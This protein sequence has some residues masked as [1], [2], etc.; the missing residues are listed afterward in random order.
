MLCTAPNNKHCVPMST[1]DSSRE[2]LFKPKILNYPGLYNCRQLKASNSN[3][4]LNQII[5][6]PFQW[7]LMANQRS[8]CWRVDFLLLETWGLAVTNRPLLWSW[9][10][11]KGWCQGHATIEIWHRGET[12]WV[13]FLGMH[14]RHACRHKF[15]TLV[16]NLQYGD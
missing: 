14:A 1:V 13:K 9:H 4:P 3:Y 12:R 16:E 8:C 10:G 2:W 11:H 15:N 6:Q 7:W 5:K